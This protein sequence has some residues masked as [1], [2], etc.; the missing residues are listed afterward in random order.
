M[1]YATDPEKKDATRIIIVILALITGTAVAYGY[2]EHAAY[3]RIANGGM[4][5]D[6][7]DTL[8][9]TQPNGFVDDN[10]S[11]ANATNGNAASGT[12]N[13]A[14]S[15][16]GNPSA[17]NSD[18]SKLSPAAGGNAGA[19][20]NDNGAPVT[21]GSITTMAPPPANGASNDGAPTNTMNGVNVTP[22]NNTG[23]DMNGSQNANQ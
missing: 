13:A 6:N 19:A 14:A 21:N 12:N 4:S 8:A 20:S 1:A 5:V 11:Q 7:V 9:A 18:L 15:T 22:G 16:A 3:V 17:N 2:Y 23:T 10:A